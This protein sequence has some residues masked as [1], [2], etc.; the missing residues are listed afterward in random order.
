ML[1]FPDCKINLGLFI[2]RRREDGYHDI[3]TLFYPLPLTDVLEIVPAKETKLHIS[4]LP[5]IGSAADN[6]VVKAHNL[7]IELYQERIPKLDIYLHKVIPMGAG[8]GGGSADGAFMLKLINDYCHLGL[9]P[10]ELIALA[11]KLGSDCPFFINNSPAF[12]M[13]RGEHLKQVALNLAAFSIQLICPSVHVSTREAFG[14]IS[15][16]PAPCNLEE[17]AGLPIQEWKQLMSNDFETPVFK[18][19]PA[20]AEI[21][22]QLY[23]QGAIYASMSGSGSAL[24]GIFPKG[25]KALVETS[26]NFSE[27]Y[28]E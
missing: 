16:H 1:C 26:L 28:M 23:D 24:Y 2:T 25:K 12:A 15:P 7:L 22:Q 14:M 19:H 4:G 8:L 21:K 27:H 11:L 17:V 9:L 5:V 3:E 6:L 10:N 20:L 13:G 18:L